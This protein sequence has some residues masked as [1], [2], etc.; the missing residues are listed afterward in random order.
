MRAT[1]MFVL[2]AAVLAGCPSSSG[3]D[4]AA[5][6]LDACLTAWWRTQYGSCAIVPECSGATG[7]LQQACAASDCHWVAFIG[8]RSDGS[9]VEGNAIWSGARSLYCAK[10]ILTG[11]W[12][13]VDAGHIQV[14][15]DAVPAE[16]IAATCSDGTA[17]VNGQPFTALPADVSAALSSR[18]AS[19]SWTAC[20][21]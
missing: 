2:L 16:T 7:D 21:Y 5:Q 8:Y 4:P 13:L 11:T 6:P 14:V 3:S 15:T 17:D 1:V 10:D 9:T 20:G 19:A 12:S 18:A